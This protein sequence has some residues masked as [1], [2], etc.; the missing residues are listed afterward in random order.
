MKK[1]IILPLLTLLVT[2]VGATTGLAAIGTPT[3]IGTTNYADPCGSGYCLT[4]VTSLTLKPTVAVAVNNTVILA[5]VLN[6]DNTP[7]VTVT[8]SGGNTYTKDADLASSANYQAR[9]LVF[10]APVTVALTTSSTITLHFSGTGVNEV[11]VSGVKVTGLVAASRVDKTATA[12]GTGTSPS[13]GNTATTTQAGELLIGAIGLD[14]STGSPTFTAGANYTALPAK[15]ITGIP[16]GGWFGIYPEYQIVSATGAYAANGTFSGGVNDWVAAIVTYKAALTSTTTALSRTTGSSS[17]TYGSTLAFTATVSGSSPTG[18]VIFKDGS[19][20]LATVALSSGTAVYTSYTDLKVS[21]SPHSIAAYYQGDSGNAA[22][23]S[24]AS[25]ISQTITAKALTATGTLSVPAS[26]VYDGTTSASV[27]GAAA[28]LATEAPGAGTTADGKPY[29]AD[30]VSLTGTASYNYNFKD[31]ATATTVTE[32][33]LSLTGTGNGNYTLTAPSF[34]AT[35]T[36]KPLSITA[37][38]IA[39]KPYDGT[40]TAGAVTVG[41]ISGFIGSETVTATAVAADYSSANAGSY[42]GDVVTYT[43]H[44][45]TGGGLAANYSLA[46]GTATGTIT[47]LAVQ[48][49]GTR[50]YD[51]TTTAAFGILSVANKV[52]SDTVNVASGSGTLAGANVGSEA[53][54]SF[55]TLALGNNSAGD[56]T[57]TG[58]SGSVTVGKAN[59]TFT[60]TPYTVTYDGSAH[61]ATAST[62]TGVNGE[63]GAT[64]GTVTLNTTHTAAG[65][66]S[67]DSWSFTGTANYNNIGSTPITDTI[68]KVTPTVTVTVG[69]YTYSGSSQ[70]PNTFTT[71]P[72]GDTGTPT[73]SY[74]GVSGTT[75]GPS[76]TPP[77][78]AGSYTAQVTALT[79]DANFNSSS[80][81][82]TSFT[83]GKATPTVSAWPTA[84]GI[85]YGQAL[86]PNSTLSGGSASVPGSFAFTTPAT[87]PSA[88]PYSASVT[89][90]PTDTA[91]YNTVI[92]SVNVSVAQKTL[93]PTVTLNN[94]VYDGTTAATTIASRSLTGIVPGDDVNLGTS[95][96]VAAFS[97]KNVGSYT[98]SVTGLSLS[99]TTAGNYVLSTA[100]VSPS[101]SITVRAITVT[102][103]TNTK[104]YDGTPSAAAVGSITSGSIA[105]GDTAPAWTE[106]YNNPNVATGKTLTAAGT[107]S[108]GNSGNN[109]AVTFVNNTSGVIN[110]ATL[111]ITANNDSKTYGQT[112]SYGAGSTAFSSTGLQNGET[113]GT[114]TITASGGT[115]VDAAVGSYN[116]TPSA[117]TGGTF[118]PA[119]YN[120]TYNNGTLTVGKALLTVAADDQTR[121]YGQDNPELTY[122]I[123]GFIN[124]E[125]TNVLSGLPDIHTDA[126]NTSTVAGSPYT[127]AVTNGTLV[128]TNNNYDFAFVD[129]ALTVTPA[130]LT[131]TADNQSKVYG[132]AVPALTATIT[133]FV[134]GEDTNVLS[135]APDLSTTATATS[136]VAGSPYTI[137][138]TNGTLMATNYDFA[139][140]SGTLTVT[141]ASVTGHIT[142]SDK[143]YDG[144]PTAT[145]AS[146]SLDGVIGSDDVSLTGGAA[147]FDNKNVGTGKSVTATGLSL[148]GADAGNYTLASSSASTTASIN[149][150]ALVVSATGSDK[151]Y[152]GT[153][154]A[155]VILSDNRVSGDNFTDSYSAA[156]FT[157]K[158]VGPAKPISVTGIAIS[159]PDAGN[160]TANTAAS[161][162]ANITTAPVTGH[163][164]ASDKTYDGLTDATITGRSLDG[165]IGSDDVILTGGTANFVDKN[166]GTGKTV[167]ATG[168]TL[169]GTDAG[170]YALASSSASTTAS[171]NLAPLTVSADNKSKTVGVSNPTLTATYV[172]FVNGEDTNVLTTAVSLGTTATDGSPV[173]TYPIT[174]SGGEAPNY[175]INYTDGTMTVDVMPQLSIV[176]SGT[177]VI[178]TCRATIST[179]T[180]Q[181]EYK[182]DLRDTAWTLLGSPTLGTGGSIAFT[183]QITTTQRFFRIDIAPGQ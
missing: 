82:A 67:S 182:D 20:T 153:A 53:I 3:T 164:T 136:P 96:T 157:D 115:A 65:A 100:S 32:S 160:Y 181:I 77:T 171:I 132:D 78:L 101:A 64:V 44:N 168:L 118:T 137:S 155:S 51:G 179:Q 106:T 2:L 26:K 124:G 142:A 7:T 150:R 161:T 145:I 81:S 19:T 175:I 72:S 113:I 29:N 56:Y 146:R 75:Y 54:T 149:A 47:A 58:A 165:V 1:S 73:W 38:T 45:G 173:G 143:T 59:A 21:G 80:S 107:V 99:G 31:V 39:S 103:A 25:P 28:L 135:G 144:T 151:V 94:K 5:I 154:S 162:S 128:A 15:I 8:D 12:T 156:S 102:A 158:N 97:S 13:S 169:T 60:V 125:D 89:F 63:T 35:I 123:T 57:L 129:G 41:T 79:S 23:D 163:I 40:A 62:I 10:S 138:V 110:Q 36:A 87:T 76:A 167:T 69:S 6:N 108:D 126:T 133:G 140:V 111:G 84:S 134:N 71:S 105:A 117:A 98:P 176:T 88:G 166:V 93:T 55:G 122:T 112:K 17:Q 4:P 83:I 37:P 170:N 139:F 43:L 178:V 95:G 148:S 131:V 18:N 16:S 66:Y 127:I 91:S 49:S 48:L 183:N 119:N 85:T 109:Y 130:P 70:G 90:T 24:S 180:Y 50:A 177:Q 86:S 52:G 121:G 46:N 174:A 68:N 14:I 61:S 116:L 9:T 11:N 120:I 92:G 33:G 152:D 34:S 114:V 30:T 141:T 172:G 104:T 147:S 27:S 42:P 159:G 74:V 22:S